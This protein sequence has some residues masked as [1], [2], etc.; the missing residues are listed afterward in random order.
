VEKAVELG[1]T[2]IVPLETS[3]GASVATRL[4]ESHLPRLRR[5]VLEGT[6]QCGAAWA[7]VISDLVRLEEFVRDA[8]AGSG[9]L[10]DQGGTPAPPL[11]DQTDVTVVIG[12]EGGLTESEREMVIS[13]GYRPLSLGQYTLRFETAAIAAAAAVTQ[14]RMRRFYG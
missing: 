10:A 3:R 12:P 13:A 2:R 1:V 11:V 6:K 8:P 7:P 14:A 4:K 5:A 9:W